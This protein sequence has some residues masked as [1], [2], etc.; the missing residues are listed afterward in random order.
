MSIRDIFRPKP[1]KFLQLLVEQ[2]T[3]TVR[4]LE[5]LKT[6]MEKRDSVIAK[7]IT[8]TEKKADEIRRILIEEL[9]H[10][11]V[12]PFDR[13]DIFSLSREIDDILDYTNTTQDEMEILGCHS[14]C[15][16]AENGLV[17]I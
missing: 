14:H 11:F 13:E 15:L 10:T 9:M 8:A 16:Y 3:L 17:V 12:T 7:E 1:N 5:L 4:G 2:T 6:Y